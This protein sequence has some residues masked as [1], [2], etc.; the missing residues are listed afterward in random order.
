M[1]TPLPDQ[2]LYLIIRFTASIPD[3]PLSIS[4]P[5]TLTT[6]S[7]KRLIR[8]HLPPAHASSRLRLIYTGKVL[9]D[10]AP[11]SLSLRLPPPPPPR[12][13]VYNDSS[14]GKGKGKEPVRD[15]PE[16]PDN[17]PRLYIHCSLGDALSPADLAAEASSALTSETSLAKQLSKTTKHGATGSTSSA[18]G[19]R[20]DSAATTAA[21][22]GFDR[23]LSAG[24]TSTEIASL[25]SQ[26]LTNI[27][28]THTPDNMPSGA[29]LRALEDRWLDSSAHEAPAGDTTA[30][31][32]TATTEG[33]TGWGA[34]FGVDDGGLDDMLFGYLTGFFW[35]L[36]AGVWGMREEGVWTRRRQVAVVMGVVLNCAF[37]FL[38]WSS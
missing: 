24:F 37:G 5:R 30:A 14:Q 33:E 17:S 4:S 32:A 23:L 18:T 6:L 16:P 25:R 27:S 35:P 20:R 34:G 26:F 28:F 12:S 31:T 7:L 19:G 8:T 38:R 3:L 15:L 21:P 9:A 13:T 36:A 22:Q 1:T 10:T 2:I 29:A 11:L